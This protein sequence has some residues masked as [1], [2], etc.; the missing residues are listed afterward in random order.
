MYVLKL[1]NLKYF[2]LQKGYIIENC[3][4]MYFVDHL[5]VQVQSIIKLSD[6]CIYSKSRHIF[7][8]AG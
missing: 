8:M 2:K 4:E 3:Q 1:K 5:N 6:I 7:G